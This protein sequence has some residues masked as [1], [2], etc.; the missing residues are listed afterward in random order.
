M[1]NKTGIPTL[2][3]LIH[4]HTRG[5][6]TL[7]CATGNQS[8]DLGKEEIKWSL[9]TDDMIACLGSSKNLPGKKKSMGLFN[10]SS[11]ILKYKVNI[12][13]VIVVL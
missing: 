1:G 10:E 8:I 3:T 9:F 11:K 5:L 2:T 4:S 6:K 12:Q 13:N 7:S